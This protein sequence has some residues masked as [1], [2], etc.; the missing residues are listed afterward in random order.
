MIRKL[1]TGL[2]VATMMVAGAASAQ[3]GTTP[4]AAGSKAGILSCHVDS[5]WGFVLFSSRDLKCSFASQQNAEERYTG[6]VEKYGVDIG[7]MRSSVI[8]WTVLTVGSPQPGALAGSYGGATGSAAV[9][10]GVGASVLVGGTGKSITLQPLNIEGQT[11]LNV[12]AGIESITLAVA[13]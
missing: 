11:G 10:G 12:A 6:K 13:K 5:G 7:Y 4:P 8:I 9:V 3:T 2:A 1:A